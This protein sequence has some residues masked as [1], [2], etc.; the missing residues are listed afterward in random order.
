METQEITIDASGLVTTDE[1][2]KAKQEEFTALVERAKQ[3]DIYKPSWLP[4]VHYDLYRVCYLMVRE[5]PESI[6]MSSTNR[7]KLIMKMMNQHISAAQE[8]LYHKLKD[9]HEKQGQENE[10][11]K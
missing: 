6:G 3:L 11:A 9:N 5:A 1:Q 7:K 8:V 4:E 10:Q 2:I